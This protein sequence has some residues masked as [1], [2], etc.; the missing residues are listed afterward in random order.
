[1][2]PICDKECV[3]KQDNYRII[4]NWKVGIPR[5]ET[6]ETGVP[7]RFPIVSLFPWHCISECRELFRLHMGDERHPLVAQNI[8][9]F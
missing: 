9:L 5:K 7:T 6:T 1:M 3:K 4:L 8:G 2:P